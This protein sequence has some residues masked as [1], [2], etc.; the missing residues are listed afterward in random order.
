MFCEGCPTYCDCVLL[1]RV[2]NSEPCFIQIR[3]CGEQELKYQDPVM[4]LIAHRFGCDFSFGSRKSKK[5]T[6]THK[7]EEVENQGNFNLSKKHR[8]INIKES[9]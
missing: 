8:K 6:L 5:A 2:A 7:N 9:N 3:I 4:I 1:S